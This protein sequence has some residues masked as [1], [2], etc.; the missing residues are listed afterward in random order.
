MVFREASLCPRLVLCQR[1]IFGLAV[2]ALATIARKKPGLAPNRLILGTRI[3][4]FD[5]A[6]D[7]RLSQKGP[8]QAVR[9]IPGGP[10]PERFAV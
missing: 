8:L 6:L 4:S 2:L 10:I 7:S 5:K 9:P 3:L 1:L